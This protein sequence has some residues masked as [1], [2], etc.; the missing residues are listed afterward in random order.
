[1]GNKTIIVLNPRR[2]NIQKHF[3]E[4]L[5][6]LDEIIGQ[7]GECDIALETLTGKNITI[8]EGYIDTVYDDVD[9]KLVAMPCRWFN[10]QVLDGLKVKYTKK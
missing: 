1:M 2:K 3:D 5:N 4:A 8:V 9:K 6:K 7:G 10:K